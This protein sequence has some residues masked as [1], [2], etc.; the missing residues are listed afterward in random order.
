MSHGR[1]WLSRVSFALSSFSVLSSD[2]PTMARFDFLCDQETQALSVRATGGRALTL[3]LELQVP[4]RGA[5]DSDT[6]RAHSLEVVGVI[7]RDLTKAS[8]RLGAAVTTPGVQAGFQ[9]S[10]H[11]TLTIV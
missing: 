7:S 10:Q 6:G 4:R 3:L 1:K 11:K 2:L 8:H 5:G 9:C